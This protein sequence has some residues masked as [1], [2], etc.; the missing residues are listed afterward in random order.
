MSPTN[1]NP[2]PMCS[3][4]LLSNSHPLD[5]P[6]VAKMSLIQMAATNGRPSVIKLLA[7]RGCNVND[8]NEIGETPLHMATKNNKLEAMDV[9]LKL[10]A[11]VHAQIDEVGHTS[12]HYACMYG[13]KEATLKLLYA[14]GDAHVQNTTV[15][16]RT[17]LETAKDSGYRPLFNALLDAETKLREEN[18]YKEEVSEMNKT[19]KHELL[20]EKIEALNKTNAM[21]KKTLKERRSEED[22]MRQ[23]HAIRMVKERKNAENRRLSKRRVTESSRKSQRSLRGGGSWGSV[24]SGGGYESGESTPMSKPGTPVSKPGT[25]MSKPG[26]PMSLSRGQSREGRAS[27]GEKKRN[28]VSFGGGGVDTEVSL[29]SALEFDGAEGGEEKWFGEDGKEEEKETGRRLNFF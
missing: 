24:G 4:Y 9:L 7:H 1:P 13:Y 19:K 5:F 17:P 10:G 16:K 3:H 11:N 21:T 8:R 27:V 6:K 12:M 15:L 2:P 14:G 25:P 20:L 28:A 22:L 18:E 29:M 26:T 23:D